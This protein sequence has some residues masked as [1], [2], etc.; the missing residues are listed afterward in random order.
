MYGKDKEDPAADR[1]FGCSGAFKGRISISLFFFCIIE[2][3]NFD[4]SPILPGIFVFIHFVFI[5]SRKIPVRRSSSNYRS[6]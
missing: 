3:G 1:F 2:Q 6:H 4:D 5:S